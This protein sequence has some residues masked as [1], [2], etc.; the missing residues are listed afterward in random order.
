MDFA[1][2]YKALS[3]LTHPGKWPLR[4][5]T[6]FSIAAEGPQIQN[7]KIPKSD[8]MAVSVH[9]KLLQEKHIFV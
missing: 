7:C 6:I 5:T 4:N 2:S 8:S 1:W 9:E 3:N